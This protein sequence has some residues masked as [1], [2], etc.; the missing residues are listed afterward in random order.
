MSQHVHRRYPITVTKTK[1][2]K[3]ETKY[4]HKCDLRS[5]TDKTIQINRVS[6]VY[7]YDTTDEVSL[8]VLE[9]QNRRCVRTQGYKVVSGYNL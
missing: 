4:D 9:K 7:N 6:C 8:F 3:E 2:V 1:V 5:K